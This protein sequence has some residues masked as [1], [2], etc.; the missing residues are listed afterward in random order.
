MYVKIK[1]TR[2]GSSDKEEDTKSNHHNHHWP[3]HNLSSKSPFPNTVSDDDDRSDTESLSKLGLGRDS[4][5]PRQS[6]RTRDARRQDKKNGIHS[7]VAFHDSSLTAI[8]TL[9]NLEVQVLIG[10]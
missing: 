6:A 1:A 4:R 3:S 9:P 10:N 2:E 7:S 5:V 8:I